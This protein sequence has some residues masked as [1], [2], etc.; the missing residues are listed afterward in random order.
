MKSLRRAGVVLLSLSLAA[1]AAADV[2]TKQKNSG[3]GVGSA[4]TGEGTQYIKGLKIRMDHSMAGQE[5]STIMDIGAKQ[6]IILNHA[7]KEADI[8]DM[9]KLAEPLSKIPVSEIKASITPTTQTRQI[10]GSTCTVHNVKV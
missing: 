1:P 8:Q 9:S 3:K 10:A 2:T 5:T 4:T 6:M 7:K